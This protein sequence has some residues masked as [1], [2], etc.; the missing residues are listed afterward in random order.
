MPRKGVLSAWVWPSFLSSLVLGLCR[1]HWRISGLESCLWQFSNQVALNKFPGITFSWAL[2]SPEAGL[3][4]R[5]GARSS[6]LAYSRC[7]VNAQNNKGGLMLL[8]VWK[9]PHNQHWVPTLGTCAQGMGQKTNVP[10]LGFPNK[11]Y[12]WPRSVS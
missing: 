7:S 1:Q 5:K 4:S 3:S 11:C 8:K 10:D 9:E 12:L 2:W 6:W